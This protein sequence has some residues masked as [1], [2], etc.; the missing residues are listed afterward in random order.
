[1]PWTGEPIIDAS[2]VKAQMVGVAPFVEAA[3]GVVGTASWLNEKA[4]AA[5]D[6][7][8]RELEMW[9]DTTIIKMNPA[10]TLVL[11]TDYHVVEPGFPFKH[12][13]NK[14][15]PQMRLRK[16]P[17]QSVERVALELPSEVSTETFLEVPQ[18]WVVPDYQLGHLD[19]VPVGPAAILVQTGQ[20]WWFPL[21][22]SPGGRYEVLPR[23]L[24][25][26]Y[27]AG[28]EDPRTDP[29]L[30]QVREMIAK[31]AAIDAIESAP[32]VIP[33][34]QSHEGFSQT[35][36]NAMTRIEQLTKTVERFKK[37]WVRYHRGPN[38]G[39]I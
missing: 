26:D 21:I 6:E 11:G 22:S 1:M 37:K 19:I 25:V 23:F 20:I 34:S 10:A 17:V 28:Y 13:W 3:L 18:N 16:R 15:I 9:F 30:V 29:E 7:F 8:E 12:E 27:T 39:F 2:L 31:R 5:Q 24:A 4:V 14:K 36:Q 35:W 32:Q 38:L 33:D